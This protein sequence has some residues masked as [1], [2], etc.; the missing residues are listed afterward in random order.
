MNIQQDIPYQL[1]MEWYFWGIFVS[2]LCTSYL[3][4]KAIRQPKL[5]AG[6]AEL[7][8]IIDENEELDSAEKKQQACSIF[9][10]IDKHVQASR[11][12]QQPKLSLRNLAD[13]LGLTEKDISWA[14][15]QGGGK[16]FSDYINTLRIEEIKQ[17]IRTSTQKI[18]L[19]DVAL[20]A[21]FNSK[22][23]FNVVFKR[24]TGMT[25]SQYSKNL[26]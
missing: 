23:T 3:I 7:E 2:L 24:I 9:S 14:I 15:N 25:P 10:G 26:T 8:K 18:N 5:Y 20:N 17:T 6:I 11:A 21:G 4:I 1:L 12:Y 13:E 19:L 16:S 22:S